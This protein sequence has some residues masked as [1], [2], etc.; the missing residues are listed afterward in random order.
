MRGWMWGFVLYSVAA[1]TAGCCRCDADDE[2][3]DLAG[4]GA[5]DCGYVL[6]GEDPEP[7]LA[8]AEAALAAGEPF[9]VGFQRAGIDSE[10]RRYVASDGATAFVLD[11]DGAPGGGGEGCPR[12]VGSTCIAQPSRI[13]E[14]D[15]EILACPYATY[16][17]LVLCDG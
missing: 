12:F 3:R 1:T 2:A 13:A 10:V 16:G 9:Y 11:Y 14:G 6:L 7:A 15:G 4:R 8:C 5:I 17:E